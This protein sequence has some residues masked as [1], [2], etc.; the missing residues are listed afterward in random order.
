MLYDGEPTFSLV[1]P[2]KSI[3]TMKK[4]VKLPLSHVQ[5]CYLK[6]CVLKCKYM[7]SLQIFAILFCV[8]VYATQEWSYRLNEVIDSLTDVAKNHN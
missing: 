7:R 1:E 8:Y 2:A 6:F 4:F 3:R 5:E